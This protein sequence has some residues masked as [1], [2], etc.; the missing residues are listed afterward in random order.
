MSTTD[1]ETIK[2]KLEG[3]SPVRPSDLCSLKPGDR[4]RY[5]V[6][7]ELR[8]GGAVKANRWPDYIV[9]LNVMNK[10]SWCMQL[11]EPTLKVWCKPLERVAKEKEDAARVYALYKEG[12]LVKKK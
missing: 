3:Y 2:K 6:N 8:G 1:K 12:K 11:K 10:A 7:N 9:L 4:V 5:M